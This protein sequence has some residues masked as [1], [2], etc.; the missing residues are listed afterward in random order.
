LKMEEITLRVPRGKIRIKAGACPRGCNLLN[1]KKLMSGK[2]AITVEVRLRGDISLLHLNPYY[3]IFEYETDVELHAGDV[4]DLVGRFDQREAG[5]L[6]QWRPTAG[7]A[8][9]Q[10]GQV[11]KRVLRYVGQSYIKIKRHV[12]LGHAANYL[13][14][15]QRPQL[16][17]QR[18]GRQT[19]GSQSRRARFN[20]QLR[21]R[22]SIV[23]EYVAERRNAAQA[24]RDL[25]RE[26]TQ[27]GNAGA[28]HVDHKGLRQ[29]REALADPLDGRRIDRKLHA[30]LARF[31]PNALAN[32]V[33]RVN[34]HTRFEDYLDLTGVGGLGIGR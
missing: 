25:F 31:T 27:F 11:V 14:I 30:G 33:Q 5:Q 7:A 28:E 4:V 21:N 2:P 23:V 22:I 19:V 15:D 9:G 26:M 18:V 13:A 1:E 12:A 10:L 34:T 8:Y 16:L 24:C 29:T 17:V 6:A 32:G 20:L 3:G